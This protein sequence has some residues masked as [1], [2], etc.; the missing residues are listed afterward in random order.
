[1]YLENW[2]WTNDI[3]GRKQVGI[4]TDKTRIEKQQSRMCYE[5]VTVKVSM[6]EIWKALG[7]GLEN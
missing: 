3:Y 7:S 6:L 4:L 1:M 5:R 2:K